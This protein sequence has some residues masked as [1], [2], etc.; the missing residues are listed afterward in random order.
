MCARRM[1]WIMRVAFAMALLFADI[2]SSTRVYP[3]ANA[4]LTGFA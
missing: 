2:S 4:A 1:I 3:N